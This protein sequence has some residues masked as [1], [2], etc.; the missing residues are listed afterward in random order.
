MNIKALRVSVDAG[1]NCG[2]DQGAVG[3]G[4]ENKMNMAVKNLVVKKLKAL[5]AVV[6]DCTPSGKLTVMQSLAARCNTS[7]TF[8]AH[9][10][11]CLHHNCVDSPNVHGAEVEYISANGLKLAQCIQDEFVKLG[12]ANRGPQ[13]RKNLYVL[14]QTDAIAVLTECGFV[15]NAGDMKL[16]NA[17][18]EAFA[19]VQGLL[20]YLKTK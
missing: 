8:K 3:I 5:G 11:L 10:H 6:K 15:G 14:K 13:M 17:E 18:K 7:N 19:I 20:K 9:I 16:Y 2:Q 4:N 1:H 12:Y